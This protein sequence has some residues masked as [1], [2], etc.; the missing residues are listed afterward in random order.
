MEDYVKNGYMC[1]RCKGLLDFPNSCTDCNNL[2]D[3][4]TMEDNMIC[5]NCDGHMYQATPN[6]WICYD[7]GYRERR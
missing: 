5:P 6:V 4:I 1:I 7:C 3:I 2:K